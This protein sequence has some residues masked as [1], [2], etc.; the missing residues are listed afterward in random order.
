MQGFE[1]L[2][3]FPVEENGLIAGRYQIVSYLGAGD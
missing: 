2:Q 1:D 3:D